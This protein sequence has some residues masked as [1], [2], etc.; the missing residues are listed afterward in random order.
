[1]TLGTLPTVITIYNTLGRTVES[2]EPIDEGVV[3]MY[4]CGPTVQSVPHLGHGR[5]A[6]A[7][8]AVRRYLMWRGYDV[9]YVQN[10]TDVDDKIIVNAAELGTTPQQL[11][12]E[13]ADHFRASS[14]RLNIL[15]PTVEPRATDHIAEMITI[16]DRLIE[17]G[18]AYPAEGDVYFRVRRLD[19]YGKL[20]GRNLDDL[21]A[22]A[23]IEPGEQKDDPLDFALWKAA[24]PGEPQWDSPWGPGR[25]GW[26]IECSAM[27]A[28]YL[29]T[30]FDIHAGGNDLIFPHH[31]NE[32][33]QSR[34][35]MANRSPILAAQRHGE[36]RWREDGQVH[37]PHYRSRGRYR[38]VWR[39][40]GSPVL[41]SSALSLSAGVLRGVA[42]R[43]GD[44]DGTVESFRT[45]ERPR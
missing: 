40:G 31:E 36:S 14:D 41:S 37:R 27:A 43:R 12:I 18:L 3:G 25:P 6:V 1:M 32:I 33:A 30:S 8:D 26:H 7:F 13:M 16:I 35:P 22:G 39:P 4:V 5:F 15:T 19:G 17:T 10:V 29:G 24:K 11:S 9:T 28:R 44:V 23:R 2:F 42:R 34:E 21:I 38:H 20:S 45:S